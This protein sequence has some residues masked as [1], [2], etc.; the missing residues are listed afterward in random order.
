MQARYP[1]TDTRAGHARL[2]GVDRREKL[3][4]LKRPA[5]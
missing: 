4:Q 3:K 2:L 5:R 1:G